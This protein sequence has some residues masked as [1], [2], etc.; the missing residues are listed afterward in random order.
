MKHR[1]L[2][3]GTCFQDL[4]WS[5]LIHKKLDHENVLGYTPKLTHPTQLADTPQEEA[6]RLDV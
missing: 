4:F 3:E 1:I 6:L 5:Y 2:E